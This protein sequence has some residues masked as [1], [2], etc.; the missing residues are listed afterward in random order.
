[1]IGDSGLT[2][3]P[4]RE[5]G[6]STTLVADAGMGVRAMRVPYEVFAGW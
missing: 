1:M 3:K 6:V 2:E 5:G 4:P